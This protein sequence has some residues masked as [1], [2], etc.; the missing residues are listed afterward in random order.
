MRNL[1]SGKNLAV[2]VPDCGGMRNKNASTLFY[3]VG[4]NIK[5][6]NLRPVSKGAKPN[7][8]SRTS[9]E[10]STRFFQ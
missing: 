7:K 4:T 8:G 5:V 9:L 1:T 2:D 6:A 10:R 3:Y